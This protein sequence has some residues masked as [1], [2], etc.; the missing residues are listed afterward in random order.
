MHQLITGLVHSKEP[1]IKSP[2]GDAFLIIIVS[3]RA[4]I[5]YVPAGGM[6]QP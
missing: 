3:E 4:G 5:P 6:L 2:P 1:L